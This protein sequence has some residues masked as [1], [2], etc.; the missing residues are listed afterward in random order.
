MCLFGGLITER[1][2]SQCTKYKF[3]IDSVVVTTVS[4]C[5]CCVV[6][7]PARNVVLCYDLVYAVVINGHRVS[8]PCFG[9]V[10]PVLDSEIAKRPFLF[11][12]IRPVFRLRGKSEDVIDLVAMWG[13]CPY[14]QLVAGRPVI[15]RVH[16][17]RVIRLLV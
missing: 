15:E 3:H 17:D 11:R 14:R 16:V 9:E 2:Q 1:S 10:S 13:T 12:V 8:L 7:E 4:L 5:C 6:V